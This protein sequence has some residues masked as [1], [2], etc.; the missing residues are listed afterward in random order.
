MLYIPRLGIINMP[1]ILV[2]EDDFNGRSLLEYLLQQ[3]GFEVI[4]AVDGLEGR[5][6]AKSETP[7]VLITDICMP[8]ESGVAMINQLRKE[9]EMMNTPIVVY[10]AYDSDFSDAAVEAGANKVFSKPVELFEV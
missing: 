7:D 6:L 4:T 1:K 5:C 9:S 10:T 8:N 2:V 3:R